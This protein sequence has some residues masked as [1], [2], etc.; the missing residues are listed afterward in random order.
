MS[1]QEL[2]RAL[3]LA[4]ALKVRMVADECERA[5]AELTEQG[6][7]SRPNDVAPAM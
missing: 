2:I 3:S 6:S 1:E 5:L 7:P 4:R